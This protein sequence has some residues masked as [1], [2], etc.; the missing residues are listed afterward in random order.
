MQTNFFSPQSEW[1]PPKNFPDLSDAKEI[2]FDLETKDTQL[3]TRGPGWMTNNGHIIGVAVAVDG[4][5]GYYPIRHENGFNFDPGRVLKWTAKTLSTDA[6]KIAHNAVYDLGW[7]HAEGIKVNGPIVDTMSMAT[8]LNENKFSYALNSVGKD[9]LNEIKDESKLKQAASDFGVDPK[10]EMYKLPA[11]FVGDYAEQDADL[12]LR[13]YKTMRVMIDKESLSSVYKLEMQILPIVFEMMKRGVRVDVEQAHRYKKT[14]KNSEKKILDSIFKDTGIAVDIW[15]ADSV[16]KVF[17]KLKIEYPRTEK[18]EK[19]SFTKD[20]L[21][22]HEHPIAQKIVQA[23]E[24]NKLQTTFLDT[25]FKHEKNNR[26]HASIHQLRDGVSGTVSGRFSYSNPNLQQLPSRNPEIKKKIRGLFLPEEGSV[27]GSFDYSQQ[28][29]R[30]ATHY[31][32]NLGCDGA[33]DVVNIYNKDPNADFHDI[34]SKI[35][36]ISRTN[37]KTINLGLLYG[38][39]VKKLAEELK[40]DKDLVKDFLAKFHKQIPF[41]KD[42]SNRVSQYANSTGYVATL[43]GRKC[44]FEL[45]EPTSF[46]VFKAL[47]YDQAKEKYGRHHALQRAGTY[48]ALNRLI[49]GSA[50]DQT[51]QAMVDL[52]N[53]GMVP[54]VQIHDE[55]TLSIDGSKETKNKIIDIMTNCVKLAV[56][57]KVDCET[58]KSWGDAT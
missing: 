8:I 28:E 7:L 33:E 31:A 20:F 37:A 45:W 40:F 35:A 2:A 3:K 55:L 10:N 15:A 47:P 52:Y 14:F 38:M 17:D 27:W 41:I 26:I 29:P 32:F 9:L 49:Q 13:L 19:P 58:G 57:S 48:K 5:K 36:N 53:E 1:L 46:G 51:K 34:V 4:W 30:L 16:A 21:S 50:A 54:L 6:I 18:T 25:I 24:F 22:K 43:K 44:R 23:R 12:T 11:I 39:G 42:L 56:P